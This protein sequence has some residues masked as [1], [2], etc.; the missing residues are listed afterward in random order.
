MIVQDFNALF[1]LC[2]EHLLRGHVGCV[3]QAFVL[4]LPIVGAFKTRWKAALKLHYKVPLASVCRECVHIWVQIKSTILASP[5]DKI[6]RHQTF[7]NVI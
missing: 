1:E 5:N 7:H 2:T 4:L 6:T 3:A